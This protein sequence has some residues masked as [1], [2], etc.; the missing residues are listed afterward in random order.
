MPRLSV[1]VPVYKVEKYIHKCIDSILNQTFTDFEL[2]LVDDGSPDSCGKICDE[3]AMKDARVR[4]IHQ[5][6]KG[7]AFTRN[8]GI[9]EAQCE[10]ISFIDSDDYILPE[11][12][13]TMIE[14]MEKEKDIDITVCDVNLFYDNNGENLIRK[15]QNINNNIQGNEL[16]E[17]FL[18]DEYPNYLANKI[19]RRKI[20][21]NISMPEGIVFEDLYIMPSLIVAAERIYYIAEG[22]YCYR[23]HRSTF[24]KQSKVKKKYGLFKAWCEHERVCEK[25]GFKALEYSR[26]RAQKAAISLKIINYADPLLSKEQERILDEYLTNI[27]NADIKKMPMKY[28]IELFAIRK[29]MVT[30]CVLFGNIS[31]L[32]QK[33]KS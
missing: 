2:I 24:N 1:I 4:V 21:K 5:I 25:Y 18:L 33:L 26:E 11:M 6:N 32:G 10:Y 13:Y 28:R 22:F 15:Y 12:F 19:F 14:I 20:F 17:R 16:K 23:Q 30:I 31:I 3:Y 27:R 29:S 7:I 8:L 9:K